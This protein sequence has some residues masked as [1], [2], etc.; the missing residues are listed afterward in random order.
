MPS[1][2]FKD[3]QQVDTELEHYSHLVRKYSRTLNLSSPEVVERFAEAIAKT[4]QYDPYLSINTRI[5]DIGSGVGLP[6]IPIAIR[7]PDL[8]IVLCEVRR[9]RAAFLERTVSSIKLGNV[10]VYNGDVQ[11]LEALPFDTVIAQAVGRLT[12]IYR[13]SRHLL[14]P[15]WSI[16][17]RK[18]T[19]AEDE[20]SEL[21]QQAEI[22][23]IQKM[24]LDDGTAMIVIKGAHR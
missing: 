4:T 12:S 5:L 17:T 6:G 7:R 24:P 20:F 15:S 1:P 10:V 14:K 9:R 13:L 11:Q 8:E 18:G 22:I 2:L 16:L 3:A 23:N 19:S 21:S